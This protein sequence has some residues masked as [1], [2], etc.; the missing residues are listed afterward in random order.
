MKVGM[1][2]C[3]VSIDTILGYTIPQRVVSQGDN[4]SQRSS[5]SATSTNPCEIQKNTASLLAQ[6]PSLSYSLEDNYSALPRS[7]A[8]CPNNL[9]RYDNETF[10]CR[11]QRGEVIYLANS[12]SNTSLHHSAISIRP[13]FIR[14][15]KIVTARACSYRGIIFNGIVGFP[16]CPLSV[17]TDTSLIS[18]TIS[19]SDRAKRNLDSRTDN[20]TSV[21]TLV[22]NPHR[23]SN[24]I[25]RA[26]TH[27]ELGKF[28]PAIEQN[29]G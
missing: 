25:E 3:L 7:I 2:V 28:E 29:L 23:C 11:V 21:R 4:Y 10:H 18:Q 27:F 9:G 6:A 12:Q 17:G 1:P 16:G 14:L 5:D 15:L 24:Q 22:S 8:K 20:T 13:T 26:R 19:F